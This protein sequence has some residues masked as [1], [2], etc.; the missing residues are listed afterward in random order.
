MGGF[1]QEKACQS[2]EDKNVWAKKI[3]GKLFLIGGIMIGSCQG[4]G[5]VS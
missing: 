2:W 4:L 3:M 1:L 5:G